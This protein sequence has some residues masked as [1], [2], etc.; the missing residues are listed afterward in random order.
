VNGQTELLDS[1]ARPRNI[2]PHPERQAM[3]PPGA[4]LRMAQ[5]TAA[6]IS[7]LF[8]RAPGRELAA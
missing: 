3:M 4:V 6:D 7:Q 8:A 1:A 2:G 5:V